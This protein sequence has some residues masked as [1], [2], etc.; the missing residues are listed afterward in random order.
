MKR[1]RIGQV[2]ELAGVGI[3]TLRF[4][5]KEGLIPSPERRSSGYRQYKPE[6]VRQVRFIRRAKELGFTLKEIQEL[7]SIR[8]SSPQTCEEIRSQV[9]A[10]AK[11]I[12]ER[13][14]SLERMKVAL[15]SL[16]E[17]CDGEDSFDDCPIINALDD[18]EHHLGDESFDA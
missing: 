14:A 6:V 17:G 18:C 4:Y 16:A 9:E 10:K 8:T 15:R 12:E 11:D 1:L 2:A 5:E 7:L 3:P 13:I